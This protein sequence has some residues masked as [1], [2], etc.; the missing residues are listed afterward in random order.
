M[1]RRG[2]FAALVAAAGL[3]A[4]AKCLPAAAPP[5]ALSD[6]L[7]KRFTEAA[8]FNSANVEMLIRADL[9]EYNRHLNEAV[10][11]LLDSHHIEVVP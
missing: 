7:S 8:A 5:L 10:A 4:L 6:L 11:A 9:E 3:P 2:F 1:N